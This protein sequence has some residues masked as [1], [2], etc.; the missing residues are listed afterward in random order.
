MIFWLFILMQLQETGRTYWPVLIPKMSANK[1]THVETTG[2]V[3]F[4]T[5]EGDGD[6]HIRM[7]D[8]TQPE[9]VKGMNKKSLGWIRK[10]CTIAECIP[11]LKCA[12]PSV[13]QVITV[14]GISRFDGEHKWYEVH[15]VEELTVKEK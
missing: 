14:K 6:I 5:L 4:T 12:Q 9:W 15:P 3:T 1:H 10:H 11:S 7:C 2:V 8:G 13:G